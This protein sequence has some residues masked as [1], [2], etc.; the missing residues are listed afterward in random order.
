MGAQGIPRDIVLEPAERVI[1]STK[2]LAMWL[3][4]TLIL[5]ASW[6]VVLYF[7][8]AGQV[9]LFA[10]FV[11]AA[12]ALTVVAVAGW[13]RWR[14]KWY[15]LTDRR[16]ITRSGI[17]DRVQSAILLDRLQDVTLERPFPLSTLRGY[18]IVRIESAGKDSEE[19][20]PMEHADDFHRALTQAL[21]PGR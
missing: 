13:L 3:P 12:V 9:G 8:S 11:I 19:R 15:I 10:L 18:G 2:P 1:L 16:I 20:I 14:A 17:L 4:V 5:L 6:I 7:W 21:T